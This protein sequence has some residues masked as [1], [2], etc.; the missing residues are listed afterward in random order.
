MHIFQHRRYQHDH[1]LNP[2]QLKLGMFAQDVDHQESDAPAN[3]AAQQDSSLP[4]VP[5][6]PQARQALLA[7]LPPDLAP[8]LTAAADGLNNTSDAQ[9]GFALLPEIC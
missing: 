8:L 7:R 6:A 2:Y 9:V 5:M 3:E 4:A 1:S